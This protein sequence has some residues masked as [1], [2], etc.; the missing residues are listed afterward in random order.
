M[1]GDP[2]TRPGT[3]CV[4][5][6]QSSGSAHPLPSRTRPALHARACLCAL[7]NATPPL[8]NDHAAC[9]HALPV[10]GLQR[11][12]CLQARGRPGPGHD[13]CQVRCF[14]GGLRR[15]SSA[16]VTCGC[17]AAHTSTQQHRQGAASGRG[18]AAGAAWWAWQPVEGSLGWHA[19]PA[20]AAF[21]AG[22]APLPRCLLCR[23]LTCSSS[24]LALRLT[25]GV[26]LS[27]SSCT[28]VFSTP[29]LAT[30]FTSSSWCRHSCAARAASS[31]VSQAAQQLSALL[32]K[33][34]RRQC[35]QGAGARGLPQ[36]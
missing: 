24:P 20:R 36:H 10:P 5:P 25:A 27:V 34:R 3:R 4:G 28:A 19:A 15:S 17:S 35:S 11:H 18:H 29:T 16:R 22:H 30:W 12:E 6:Q 7:R 14:L 8:T 1:A 32:G 9:Q 13:L 21:A 23:A 26:I 31:N 33:H 2:H